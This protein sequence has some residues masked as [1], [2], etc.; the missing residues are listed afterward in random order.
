[1]NLL[2]Y[3]FL[4]PFFVYGALGNYDTFDSLCPGEDG[5]K[6]SLSAGEYT[7]SC[8]GYFDWTVNGARVD[9]QGAAS[10]EECARLCSGSA[11]CDAML[12]DGGACWEYSAQ[13]QTLTPDSDPQGNTILLH[14]VV[15]I[16][17]NDPSN[18]TPQ[19]P[20]PLTPAQLQQQLDQCIQDKQT[21]TDQ[22]DACVPLRDQ[23]KGE[24]DSCVPLRDQYRRERDTCVPLRDQYRR[25]RDTCV[26]LR[27][28]YKRERDQCRNP[29]SPPPIPW[30]QQASR[31]QCKRDDHTIVDTGTKR[32]K[33]RCHA[34]TGQSGRPDVGHKSSYADCMDACRV[35]PTCVG[36]QWQAGRGAGGNK[37]CALFDRPVREDRL[38]FNGIASPSWWVGVTA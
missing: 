31:L 12:F 36:F 33:L 18:Q 11:D 23:Y 9:S 4:L 29:P 7:V 2:R 20:P 32:F 35:H 15:K 21:V 19:P 24:R 38:R 3:P 34:I 27:D 17:P 13:G 14:P 1:M 6:V 8:G 16:D 10:P 22:R 26:P 37:R 5:N 30:R 28:Q 25:E